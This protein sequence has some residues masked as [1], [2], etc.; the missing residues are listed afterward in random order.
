MISGKMMRRLGY[1]K[2]AS[3]S[4]NYEFLVYLYNNLIGDRVSVRRLPDIYYG[5]DYN[6]AYGGINSLMREQ[7]GMERGDVP[8]DSVRRAF[9]NIWIGIW[10]EFSSELSLPDSCERVLSELGIILATHFDND[11]EIERAKAFYND[12]LGWYVFVKTGQY[13]DAE[14]LKALVSAPIEEVRRYYAK[15]NSN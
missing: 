8:T 12:V 11:E 5:N 15:S 1:C 9:N 3:D 6:L 10:G 4:F 7:V 13:D 2:I 14:L